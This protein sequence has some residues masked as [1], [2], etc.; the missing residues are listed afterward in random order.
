MATQ[1]LHLPQSVDQARQ[2]FALEQAQFPLTTPITTRTH[3]LK[4][5]T[6]ARCILPDSNHRNP[7]SH[8][9]SVEGSKL[10]AHY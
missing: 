3:M 10:E 7:R 1:A 6:L 8:L 5:V 2:M 4:A 9:T